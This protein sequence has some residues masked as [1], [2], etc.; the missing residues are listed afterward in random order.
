MANKTKVKYSFYSNR[1]GVTMYCWAWS[2][3]QAMVMFRN[4][5]TITIG[6]WDNNLNTL[7]IKI[8]S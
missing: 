4:K 7:N 5:L 3:A 8:V 6:C 1:R 2:K